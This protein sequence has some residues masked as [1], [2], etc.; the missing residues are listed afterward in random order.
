MEPIQ[1]AMNEVDDS[2]IF[3]LQVTSN[4]FYEIMMTLTLLNTVD[5]ILRDLKII[6]MHNI[7][8]CVLSLI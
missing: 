3:E 8:K 2:K 4:R 5:P 7:N 6:K 1:N